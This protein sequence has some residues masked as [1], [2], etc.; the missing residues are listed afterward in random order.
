MGLDHEMADRYPS[1]L[2][3]GQR[4][5]AGV[6]RALA[7]DPP[8][9]LMD[10]PFGAVD[11]L[12]RT[13]LQREL[14]RA[15]GR[16]AQDDR[17]RHPRHRR[18]NPPRGP[19]RHPERRRRPRAVRHARGDPRH[20]RQRLRGGLP[21][22]RARPQAT[23]ADPGHR[24]RPRTGSRR[25][26]VRPGRRRPAG[27]WTSTAPTGSGVLDGQ[28]LRGW[29][30]GDELRDDRPVGDHEVRDF[31]VWIQSRATLREALDA[32]VNTPQPG[33]RGLRRGRVPGDA[34][35]RPDQ[36]R[37]DQMTAPVLAQSGRTWFDPSLDRRPPR[38]PVAGHRRAPAAHRA[39]PSPSGS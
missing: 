33:R 10:E 29:V 5:R 11:P 3:G 12:V 35:R 4:Q 20:P 1:E 31:R 39:S 8:V 23:R 24:R 17:L 25:G 16:A 7:A 32:V 18:G 13:R 21:R 37:A 28:R 9:L 14:L 19:H 6:A 15:A 27:S 22:Q 34:V 30:W 36:R 38:R 26:R 2:S